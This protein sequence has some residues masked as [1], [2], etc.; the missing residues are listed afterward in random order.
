MTDETAPTSLDAGTELT[1]AT[2][3]DLRS[4]VAGV[5]RPGMTVELHLQS[6]VSYDAA[7]L[8][9]LMGLKRRLE[10][11]DGNLVC[12]NPSVP[13]YSG[14]RKLGLQRVLVIR[15]DIPTQVVGVEDT[16]LDSDVS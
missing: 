16:P 15:L 9:L 12:V 4:L 5:A 6:V 13:L 14:I 10:A 1:A 7:G 8:G 11:M 3:A 2:A